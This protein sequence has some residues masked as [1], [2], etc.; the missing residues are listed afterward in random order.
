MVVTEVAIEIVHCEASV[1]GSVGGHLY[2]SCARNHPGGTN[3]GVGDC[4]RHWCPRA[5]CVCVTLIELV[6]GHVV[7]IVTGT[8]GFRV[9]SYSLRS[10]VC[11]FGALTENLC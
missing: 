6:I 1:V 9:E 8:L 7:V 3:D 4:E 5:G 2:S 11:W 10:V